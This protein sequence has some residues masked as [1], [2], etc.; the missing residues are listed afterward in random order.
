[1]L[2]VVITD[3]VVTRLLIRNAAQTAGPLHSV[4][5]AQKREDRS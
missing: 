1:L 4:S 2:I 3:N 5:R